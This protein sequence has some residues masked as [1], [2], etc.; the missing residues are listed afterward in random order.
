MSAYLTAVS[1]AA[2]VCSISFYVMAVFS[3]RWCT[4]PEIKDSVDQTKT[5]TQ[6]RRRFSS[7]G[8]LIR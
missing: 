3:S 5:R 4:A 6:A 8:R 7:A 2:K 1:I